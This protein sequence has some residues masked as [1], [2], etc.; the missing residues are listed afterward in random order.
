MFLCTLE[1]SEK[2]SF[3]ANTNVFGAGLGWLDLFEIPFF[4]G[5][6]IGLNPILPG[7]FIVPQTTKL[8]DL[9]ES[10]R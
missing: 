3:G 10:S 9:E 8:F 1:K 7:E 6:G 4:G 5:V 2:A